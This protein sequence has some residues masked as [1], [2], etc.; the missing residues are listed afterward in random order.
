MK[1]E[2]WVA[3]A[4]IIAC[5]VGAGI[6]GLPYVFAQSG[7]LV[8]V[9]YLLVFA[10]GTILI[11][12]Y[13]VEIVLR[14][15][16]NHQLIGL[17]SK[18]LGHKGK[19]LFLLAM[20]FLLYG[21]MIAYLIGI[22]YALSSLFGGAP[23]FWS[24]ISI[25]I[26][27]I[28]LYHDI[29]VFKRFEGMMVL[30]LTIIIVFLAITAI[31]KVDIANL[32]YINPIN[33]FLPYGVVLYAFAGLTAIPMIKEELSDYKLFRPAVLWG[34]IGSASLYLLFSYAMVGLFGFNVSEVSTVGIGSV[35]G[36]NMNIIANVLAV[37]TLSTSIVASG[38]ALK[39]SFTFDLTLGR[40]ASYV[41]MMAVPI[42]IV[43]LNVIGFIDTLIYVG[44]IANG[45]IYVLIIFVLE[46]AR[47]YGDREPE[48]KAP[49][50]KVLNYVLMLVYILGLAYT[51]V[52]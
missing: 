14:T 48:I 10:T 8:G 6:L 51:L 15:R 39:Q 22:G 3:A 35:L 42:L 23:L 47:I 28:I 1:K 38:Y 40:N 25:V 36:G 11:S 5:T 44:G 30:I 2:V 34:V 13:V 31:P 17:T 21:S 19:F 45:I 29:D 18:Y 27:S 26:F 33:W 41:L 32:Q 12:F 49:N 16:E 50:S 43:L 52:M 24:I 20:L 4:T 9:I 37:L 7:F 46:K